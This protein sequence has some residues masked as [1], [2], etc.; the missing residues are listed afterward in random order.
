MT[1]KTLNPALAR[2]CE[3]TGSETFLLS[4]RNDSENSPNLPDLQACFLW[5]RYGILHARARLIASLAFDGR[6]G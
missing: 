2:H 3:E 6:R 5:E 4:S 1:P